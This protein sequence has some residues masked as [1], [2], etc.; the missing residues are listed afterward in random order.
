[1]ENWIL[2]SANNLIN[3]PQASEKVLPN[4]VKV[5]VTYV[6]PT[7]YDAL[8]FGGQIEA[9][10]P[11][12]IGRI[13]TGIVTEV[14][15]NC[16]GI[17]KNMRV[18]LN[19]T[20]NC[21][22]CLNCKNGESAACNDI[23]IAGKD[24]DGFLRDFVILDYNDVT[25]LPDG[26]DDI[27]ALCIETIGIAENIYDKLNLSAG[28]RVAVFGADFAGNI[29][30]QVL[31]YHKIVPI[32]IDN[33]QPN[34]DRVK[35]LGIFHAFTAD[36]GLSEKVINA[37][38]GE[39]CDAAVYCTSS[40]QPITL[41][42]HLISKGTSLVFYIDSLPTASINIADIMRKN[43]NV[44]SASNAYDYTDVVVNMLLR[45]AVSCDFFDKEII[46]EFDPV[47]V[48]KQKL[49][50]Y[51]LGVRSSKLTVLKMVL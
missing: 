12:T 17:E 25:P 19:P 31:Q 6:M 39:M 1:M 5:K 11:K 42:A 32:V 24:F 7:W 45:N 9:K 13:A 36:E 2:K 3:E 8:L 46:S 22:V 41:A 47:A 16:Y 20:R 38:S 48:L 30:A 15:E 43:M 21:N 27:S 14:G 49:D 26:V 28:Q 4:E 40:R 34:L 33:N 44:F 51:N 35:K 29:M 50:D 10:Y 18:L 23:L 37:T